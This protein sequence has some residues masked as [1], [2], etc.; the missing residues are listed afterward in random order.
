MI[1]FSVA[2][3]L[4]NV[5]RL[6]FDRYLCFPCVVSVGRIVNFRRTTVLVSEETDLFL[7]S[8]TLE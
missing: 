6:H 4:N 7:T 8:E 3:K 2:F 5:S 1:S